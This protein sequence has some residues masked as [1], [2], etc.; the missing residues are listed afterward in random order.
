MSVSISFMRRWTHWCAGL[1]LNISGMHPRTG[2]GDGPGGRAATVLGFF[3]M[4][5]Y[6]IKM[7]VIDIMKMK[8]KVNMASWLEP[9]CLCSRRKSDD[10]EEEGT[11][12]LSS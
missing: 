2:H 9:Q 4:N 10:E 8:M 6:L 5:K 3:F 12:D 7:D 11:C 1:F